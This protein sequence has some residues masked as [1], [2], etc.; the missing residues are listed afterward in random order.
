MFSCFWDF[1]AD[2]RMALQAGGRG[3][4]GAA[5]EG[6]LALAIINPASMANIAGWQA[7]A[8]YA[9]KSNLPW[10]RDYIG[11]MELKALHPCGV[12]SIGRSLNDKIQ[13]GCFVYDA[14]SYVFDAGPFAYLDEYGNI[15]GTYSPKESIRKATVYLPA[16]I[17]FN[18]RIQLGFGLEGNRCHRKKNIGFYE[19]AADFWEILP[20]AGA[21]YRANR[22]ISLGLAYRQG[23]D[24]SVTETGIFTDGGG[25]IPFSD[26]LWPSSYTDDYDMKWTFRHHEP[27][28]IRFGVEYRPAGSPCSFL[29]D[30]EHSFVPDII[31]SLK[32]RNDLHLGFEYRKG[33]TDY[34]AG[35][36]TVRDYR[37]RSQYLNPGDN[38]QYFLTGGLTRY[39]G[40]WGATLSLMDSHLLTP[41]EWKTTVANGGIS[42]LF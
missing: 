12:L 4:T 27:S 13:I 31:S 32:D 22:A 14:K 30:F 15:I 18:D 36:F 25:V 7:F 35:F 40:P 23:I 37:V 38:S 11:G 9:Y 34:R 24:H 20:R 10:L 42:Y 29:A 3:Y 16:S 41:G 28:T 8:G 19:A 5:S 33:D 1:Y 21:V 6:E 26:T 39:F 2:N 17:R